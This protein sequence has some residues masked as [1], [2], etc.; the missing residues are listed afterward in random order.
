ME[1]EK[2]GCLKIHQFVCLF[3]ILIRS[4]VIFA[5]EG[6]SHTSTPSI[7]S[8]L[9]SIDLASAVES[10]LTFSFKTRLGYEEGQYS[11]LAPAV[12]SHFGDDQMGTNLSY[13]YR[14]RSFSNQA[15]AD[16]TD[17]DNN[18]KFSANL[19]KTISEKYKFS[20]LGETEQNKS[21]TLS[22]SMNNYDYYSISATL[23]NSISTESTASLG[24]QY[25]KRNY[26]NGTYAIPIPQ[27]GSVGEP[28][29]PVEPISSPDEVTK[30]GVSDAEHDIIISSNSI[31]GRK[32]L[33][34]EARY[35]INYSTFKSRQYQ[36]R[37][38]KV[39][40]DS[41]LWKK[42]TLL[43]SQ[44]IEARDYIGSKQELYISELNLVHELGPKLSL[45]GLARY[46]QINILAARYWWEGYAQLQLIF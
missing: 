23:A 38:L 9:N 37:A 3:F 7:S 18:H 30:L 17:Y 19:K 16:G 2:R 36:A 22:R 42:A 11:A 12:Y 20:A 35:A 28:I 32:T 40:V 24:Y 8:G 14:F 33:N 27:Q 46:N 25:S 15:V 34:L 41:S 43:L 39:G 44:S 6:H 31:L 4:G 29:S 45:L 5:H 13:K 1:E 21:N 26:P 10:P